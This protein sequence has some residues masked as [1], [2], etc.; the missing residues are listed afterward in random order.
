MWV[1]NE[2]EPQGKRALT[3]HPH[4]VE[5]THYWF[6]EDREFMVPIGQ[7]GFFA[8]AWLPKPES[9]TVGRNL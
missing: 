2:Q 4:V 3:S 8:S 5:W 7:L 6:F 9:V 1:G